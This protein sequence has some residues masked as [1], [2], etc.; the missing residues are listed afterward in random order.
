VPVVGI[1]SGK[2]GEGQIAVIHDLLGLT[3]NPPAFAR[4]VA[5]LGR[6]AAKALRAWAAK[7][8][9]ERSR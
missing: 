8:R 7:V 5:R 4:P 1:G 2:G 6:D 9:R 3:D